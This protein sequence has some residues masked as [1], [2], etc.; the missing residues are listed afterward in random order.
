MTLYEILLSE[1]DEDGIPVVECD[2]PKNGSCSIQTGG[3]CFIGIGNNIQTNADKIVH[4]AHEMGHCRTGSFYNLYSVYDN[5]AKK[6]RR[7]D[8]WAAER[9]VP[10]ERYEEAVR[11]GCVEPWQIAE[12]FGITCAF[13]AKVMAIR[14]EVR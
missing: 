11:R 3:L 1:A 12:E 5:R 8:E 9:L 7:A 2:L 6:E 14:S 10:V 13:A 4:L